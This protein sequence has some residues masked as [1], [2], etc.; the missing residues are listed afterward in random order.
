MMQDEFRKQVKDDLMKFHLIYGARPSPLH[1]M[2]PDQTDGDF[3]YEPT[4]A[5]GHYRSECV[6]SATGCGFGST[7]DADRE[8]W[9]KQV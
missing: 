2:L 8:N 6:E 9:N 4:R 1:G 5:F 7:A 3:C